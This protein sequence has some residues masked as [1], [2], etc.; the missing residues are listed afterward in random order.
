MAVPN[1]TWGSLS[2]LPAASHGFSLYLKV[3]IGINGSR[4]RRNLYFLIP[5]GGNVINFLD[6]LGACGCWSSNHRQHLWQKAVLCPGHLQW[7]LVQLRR[8]IAVSEWESRGVVRDERSDI[9]NNKEE[10]KSGCE[11][12]STCSVCSLIFPWQLKCD[13][14]IHQYY[15]VFHYGLAYKMLS[16]FWFHMSCVYWGQWARAMAVDYTTLKGHLSFLWIF[17]RQ[18]DESWNTAFAENIL[19]A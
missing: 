3:Q 18:C 11:L 10:N 19:I 13:C 6:R 9:R 15:S 17:L 14:L 2:W 5:E 12:L 8:C 4:R 16:Q 7:V 1:A